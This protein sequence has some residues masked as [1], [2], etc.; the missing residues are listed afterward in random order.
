MATPL[1]RLERL[2]DSFVPSE[3]RFKASVNSGRDNNLLLHSY[4]VKN[5]GSTVVG[6]DEKLYYALADYFK[7]QWLADHGRYYYQA[8]ANNLFFQMKVRIKGEYENISQ[9]SPAT[10]RKTLSF[11]HGI[12]LNDAKHLDNLIMQMFIDISGSEWEAKSRA[13]KETYLET[14]ELMRR[15]Y[16]QR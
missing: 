7:E 2:I 11:I 14:L 4:K 1:E 13:D 9:R 16:G 10:K 8:D 5:G 12:P 15:T 6:E 3:V